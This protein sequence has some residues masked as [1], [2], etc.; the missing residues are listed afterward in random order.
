MNR[1]IILG[2][3]GF[4]GR[5]LR[6]K[7]SDEK[8]NVKYM[9]H[10]K[11]KNLQKNE[12]FGDVLDKKSLLKIVKDNDVIV[13]LVGQYS[14][15]LSKFFDINI[16]GGLN[17]IEIAKNKKNIK[18]IF[19]S[20]INVYGNNCKYPS[21]ETDIPNPSTPYGIGKFLTEQLYEKYSK[22][23]E[24][25]VTILRFSNLYGKHKK[26]GVI[27]KLIKFN[28]NKPVYFTHNGNHQRD[29]LYVDDAANGIIKVIKKQPR[30]FSIFNISSQNKITPKKIA[31][32]IKSISNKPVFFKLTKEKP[33]E[34][35]IWANN[36][37][38]H[39]FFGFIPETIF[40][41]G[42]KKILK[43]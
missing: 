6:Q 38:A 21:K 25:D 5:S 4:L 43:Q 29:F 17:L 10:K 16:K 8:F 24:F 35:C 39:K 34:K 40:E 36:S 23:Y 14:K 27:S 1:I 11:Q 32:N 7:L 22:L 28:S 19:A 3:T 9:V 33:N 41:E 18:I 26:S 31:K 30:K 37:K 20:S 15:N 13:N 42:L 12:F 2:S